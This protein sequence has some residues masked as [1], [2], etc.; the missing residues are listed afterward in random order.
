MKYFSFDALDELFGLEVRGDGYWQED[1]ECEAMCGEANAFYG[2]QHT[3]ES[4]E[5]MRESAK[6]RNL[7]LY[8][9]KQSVSNAKVTWTFVSPEYK[10]VRIRGSLNEFCKKNNLN[11]G[12]MAALHKGKL[13]R[14]YQHK[15]WRV[16]NYGK[17]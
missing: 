1:F 6:K 14:G 11:T 17:S 9:E 7:T 13:I 3:D 15:G 10:I 4:K 2:Q 12:A 16:L 8:R 5:Q